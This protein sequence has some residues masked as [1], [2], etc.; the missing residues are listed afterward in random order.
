MQIPN[1]YCYN[2][3]A[4]G[5]IKM[6]GRYGLTATNDNLYKRYHMTPEKEYESDILEE[7]F[8]TTENPILLPNNHFYNIKWGFTP[9]FAKRPLI[10]ARAETILEKPTFSVPFQKKRCI[11]PATYFFEWQKVEGQNQKDKKKIVVKDLPIFSMAGICERY[12]DDQG[13][14]HLTY[15]IITTDANPQMAEIHDRMPVIIEPKDE[16][17]Y[18]DLNKNPQAL[19][20]LLKPTERELIINSAT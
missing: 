1:R 5:V 4:R 7:I 13:N 18:L 20:E 3:V 8:P 6:C 19:L 16:K 15:A 11:I 2:K 14:S 17:D 10:N 9:E 12:N